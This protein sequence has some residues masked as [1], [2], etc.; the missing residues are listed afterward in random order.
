MALSWFWGDELVRVH[1]WVLN[2]WFMDLPWLIR[3]IVRQAH[4]AFYLGFALFATVAY[5]RGRKAEAGPALL[6]LAVNLLIGL[7]LVRL[8]KMS[9]G[10][11]R[12]FLETHGVLAWQPYAGDT[13]WESLPSGHTTDAFVGAGLIRR[14]Y[15][16]AWLRWASLGVAILVGVSRVVLGK[17][18][19]SDVIS[20]MMLGYL[21]GYWMAGLW[22]K[23]GFR[24]V[25]RIWARALLGVAVIGSAVWAASS[26][27]AP[28]VRWNE[29]RNS[30]DAASPLILPGQALGQP[31]KLPHPR[32]SYL[33]LRFGTYRQQADGRIEL[34]LLQGAQVPLEEV[35]ILPRSLAQKVIRGDSLIDNA[36]FRWDL[37][38][39]RLSP[40]QGLYL[41]V[42]RI[43]QKGTPGRISV[44]LDKSR[45]RTAD[46][47]RILFT[48]KGG[49]LRSKRAEGQIALEMGYD[50]EPS[51]LTFWLETPRGLQI[52]WLL[53]LGV[54]V[55]VFSLPWPRSRR[56]RRKGQA[57]PDPGE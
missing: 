35:E 17:H 57:G 21:G 32:L 9:L 3:L 11:P 29:V 54:M 4:W 25:L 26:V 24:P 28:A 27:P 19:P 40:G 16:P 22:Q 20:G 38:P 18:Y 45:D 44:W 47:A 1:G 53:Q 50:R 23:G 49:A 7:L 12:P 14:L 46:P 30:L 31:L 52:S 42:V 41:I 39:L 51:Y 6:Y 33:S 56:K 8:L 36:P 34:R 13:Y 5:L 43:P 55:L 15:R 48:Q 2:E 37:P 10:R